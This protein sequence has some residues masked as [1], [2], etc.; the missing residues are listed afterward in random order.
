ML[1]P[2]FQPYP[3]LDLWIVPYFDHAL[4]FDAIALQLELEANYPVRTQGDTITW[5]ECQWVEGDHEALHYRGNALKRGKM[6]LQRGD[7]QREGFVKYYYTGW[8]H[9][10]LPATCAATE[11]PE[12]AALWDNYDQFC[13]RH[14]YP[15]ANHAIVTH[16]ADGNHCIGKHF[17]KPKSIQPKSLI[18]IIKTGPSARHFY[19]ARRETPNRPFYCQPVPPGTAIIMTVEANL[20]TVHAVPAVQKAG[21][22]GS[23]VFRTITERIT[24]TTLER[25]LGKS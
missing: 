23:I 2:E 10:V 13:A 17:D 25:K 22:S 12:V 6:W 9:K 19:L 8:Q 5:G 18:T 15:A 7:P 20:Q 16:Y 4:G 14:N 11:C 24:W 1:S 3:D 21:A